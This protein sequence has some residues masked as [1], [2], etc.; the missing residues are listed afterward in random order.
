MRSQHMVLACCRT[1][2]SE[3]AAD[4]ACLLQVV[5]AQRRDEGPTASRKLV[6]AL[7]LVHAL[8]ARGLATQVAWRCRL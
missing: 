7:E 1:A 2:L 8:E 3:L 5:I 6:N 4:C